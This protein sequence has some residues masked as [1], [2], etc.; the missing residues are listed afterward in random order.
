METLSLNNGSD[1]GRINTKASR[2]DETKTTLANKAVVRTTSPEE[3]LLSL[4][5]LL[6]RLLKQPGKNSFLVFKN[7]KYFTIPTDNIAFFYV[8]YG[9]T[10]IKCFD[11][12]EY[13]VK[14]SLKEV[15]ELVDEKQFF[16]LNRQY[17]VN[18]SAIKETEHYFARKL[19]V[20]V[21]VPAPE[22]LLI[23]KEN[24]NV[25]LRWLENR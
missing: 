14:Y 10:I 21:N 5:D 13:F 20:N 9:T 15:Q 17:L 23:N 22:K 3:N 19:L 16:R 4:D 2:H 8:K 25:F 11:G 24:G 6:K 12:K 1:L 18:F 7:Q